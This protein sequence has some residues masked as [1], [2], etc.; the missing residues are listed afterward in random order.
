MP[1]VDSLV[2]RDL[3]DVLPVTITVSDGPLTDEEFQALCEQYADYNLEATA[4]GELIIMPPNYPRNDERNAILV[5]ALVTWSR[6][7]GRGRAFG[8]TA[9]FRLPNGARR[10][11]DASWI[12]RTT[13]AVLP[14]EQQQGFYHLTPNFLVEL[15]STERLSRAKAKMR[16]YMDNGCELAWLIDPQNGTVTIYRPNQ[17]PVELTRPSELH[18][19][20]PVAGF[21][22]DLTGILD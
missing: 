13:I 8:P 20:G 18:G 21:V 1:A 9:G 15:R 19:E 4:E 5:A 17:E 11:P 2:V 14:P 10:S 16:E 3:F 7:D 12:P 6:K 22:L